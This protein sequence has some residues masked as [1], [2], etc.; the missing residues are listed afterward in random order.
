MDENFGENIWNLYSPDPHKLTFINLIKF[1]T[2]IT[3]VSSRQSPKPSYITYVRR[4]LRRCR[5]LL[6]MEVKCSKPNR[7]W[8]EQVSATIISHLDL[9][10]YRVVLV[11][12][13]CASADAEHRSEQR[14]RERNAYHARLRSPI[15]HSITHI[16]KMRT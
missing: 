5:T 7:K 3:H 2:H 4:C 1:D 10:Y 15:R 8:L 11:V 12:S 13:N 16:W 6:C 9:L 14:V